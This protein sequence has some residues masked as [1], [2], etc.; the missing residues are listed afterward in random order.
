MKIVVISDTHMPRMSKK[1]PARLIAEL[2]DADAI[3]HAGDWTSADVYPML[4]AYAPTYGVLGNNDGPEL[5]K[6]F[7]L[8]KLLRFEGCTIGLVHGHGTNKSVATEARAVE[9]FRGQQVDVIVYGHSH[10]P[11]L[12]R[13]G[14]TIVLNPGSP[15]DKRRQPRYSFAIL[16]IEGGKVGAQLI[17]YD[18]K[19]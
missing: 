10:T 16:R 6:K 4:T 17:V 13:I 14:Q 5:R 2:A 18:D 3:L 12:K 11:V 9:A 7:G 19:S 15:T 1:L 8:K